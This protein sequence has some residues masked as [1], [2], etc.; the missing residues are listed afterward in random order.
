MA[1]IKTAYVNKMSTRKVDGLMKIHSFTG[2]DKSRVSRICEEMDNLAEGF[3]N[4]Q[5]EQS[6]NVGR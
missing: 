3:H 5:L 4:R 1:I 2:N 6:L